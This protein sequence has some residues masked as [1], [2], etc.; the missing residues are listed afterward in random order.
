VRWR[1]GSSL[2]PCRVVGADGTVAVVQLRR[3]GPAAELAC[4]VSW[5]DP[6]AI[7]RL[8]VASA[9]D[10]H[11]DVVVRLGSPSLHRGFVGVPAMGPRLACLMLTD[12]PAPPLVDWHLTM[13]DVALF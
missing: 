13:A 8:L 12:Q 2:Q 3:R 10:A 6:K 5:G 4:L 9:R 1:F 7:D 11:A